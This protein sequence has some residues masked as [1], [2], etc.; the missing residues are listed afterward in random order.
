MLAPGLARKHGLP[1]AR[2]ARIVA[3]AKTSDWENMSDTVFTAVAT[4][5][6]VPQGSKKLVQVN[7]TEVLLCHTQDRVFAV[8]NLCSHA[9]EKLDCGRMR[10][11]WIACPI[12]GARFDLATGQPMNPPANQ[13]IQT[14]AVRITGDTIEVA[15]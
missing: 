5:D 14:F 11:G 12:H 15:V 9:E 8:E 1:A 13:P 6:E 7:G 2:Y 10:A 3:I 4:M